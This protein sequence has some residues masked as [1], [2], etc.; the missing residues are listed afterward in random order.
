MGGVDRVDEQAD[1]ALV[2]KIGKAPDLKFQSVPDFFPFGEE[3]SQVMF[4]EQRKEKK[5]VRNRKVG[6]EAEA[7]AAANNEDYK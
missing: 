2:Q 1:S 6:G 3:S 4:A 7:E 5:R